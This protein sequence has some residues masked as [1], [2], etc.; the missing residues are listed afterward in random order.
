MHKKT[1]KQG[2][3][4]RAIFQYVLVLLILA[5]IGISSGWLSYLTMEKTTLRISLPLV[6]KVFP[7]ARILKNDPDKSYFLN[8]NNEILG[9]GLIES[10]AFGYGG[11]V[12]LFIAVS[13]NKNIAGIV[14]LPNHETEEYLKYVA[15]E[16]LLS[17]WDNM[18]VD[19]A[20]HSPI[21]SIT[22]ATVTSDAII[23]GVRAGVAG[24]VNQVQTKKPLDAWRVI[25]D[26][27]FLAVIV[28]SLVMAYVQP[29]KKI[30]LLY[31]VTLL[32]VV[33]ILAGQVLSIK[34]L[35]GWLMNGISW[36]ANWYSAVL[37]MLA[38][39]MPFMRKPMFYCAYLCPMGALQELLNKY[40]PFRKRQVKLRWRN[41]ALGEVY[42]TLIWVSLVL[43][44]KPELS[45]LEPFMVFSYRVVGAVFFVVAFMIGVLSL[46]FYK[47]WCA[48]CPTGCLLKVVSPGKSSNGSHEA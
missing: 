12:P 11:R 15:N 8:E 31:I 30:R 2:L 7:E 6:Q 46:F 44:F 22:G 47:P 37:A 42:L 5:A 10:G 24:Y 16:K 17:R 20:L 39:L 3:I 41:I 32:L 29:G 18:P 45:Y 34:L 35:H 23:D 19:M 48:I 14:L 28:A 13:S 33:G 21:D 27:L 1:I 36:Q 43:G 25:Q 9:S 26:V 4:S 40:T 38:I